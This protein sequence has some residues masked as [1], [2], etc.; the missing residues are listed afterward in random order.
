[1]KP[2]I[3]TRDIAGNMSCTV[4]LFL[5]QPT[6]YQ[7]SRQA[8]KMADEPESGEHEEDADIEVDVEFVENR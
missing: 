6:I 4:T 8:S 3:A 1:M 5:N 2:R 7:S